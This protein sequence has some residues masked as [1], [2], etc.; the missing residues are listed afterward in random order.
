PFKIVQEG[1][2]NLSAADR[3][4]MQDYRDRVSRL[5]RTTIGVTE[6]M[7]NLNIRIAAIKLAVSDAPR[8]T[9]KMRAE[10]V[11]IELRL[12]ALDIV[13]RGDNTASILVIPDSPGL[14]QRVGL[15]TFSQLSSPLPPTQSRIEMLKEAETEMGEVLPK[16][17][18]I[19]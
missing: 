2:S 5:Q 14:V 13:L 18:E 16:L 12:K 1:E 4:T 8:A 3:K 9:P 7:D 17:R 6:L 19:A 10:A 15:V 11:A